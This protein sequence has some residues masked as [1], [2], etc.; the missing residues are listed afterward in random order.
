MT[1]GMEPATSQDIME[2]DQRIPEKLVESREDISSPRPSARSP[3][4][5]AKM[6]TRSTARSR[7]SAA[8][9]EDKRE[10]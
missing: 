3:T 7:K 1:E 5:S 9:K 6:T 4:P 8:A 2:E 10:M